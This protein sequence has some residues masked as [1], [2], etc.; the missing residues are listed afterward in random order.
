MGYGGGGGSAPYFLKKWAITID[1]LGFYCLFWSSFRH[2]ALQPSPHYRVRF[3]RG[4]E[5]FVGWETQQKLC[6]G[7]GWDS[8]RVV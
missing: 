6:F 8:M 7:E 1:G 4:G 3:E 2:T 5:A